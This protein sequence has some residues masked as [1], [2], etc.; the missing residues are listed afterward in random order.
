MP[1]VN[2]PVNRD[3][4]IARTLLLAADVRREQANVVRIGRPGVFWATQYADDTWSVYGWLS[5]CIVAH[6]TRQEAERLIT[7]FEAAASR[8]HEGA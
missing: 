2:P 1:Y 7:M 8:D 4:A 3:V 5:G 6:T